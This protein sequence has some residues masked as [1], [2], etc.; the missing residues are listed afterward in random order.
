[1]IQQLLQDAYDVHHKLLNSKTTHKLIEQ[2]AN[3]SIQAIQTNKKIILCGNGGSFT[4]RSTYN[5]RTCGT[6]HP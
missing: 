4:E 5:G 6:F 2:L 1:M 3:A